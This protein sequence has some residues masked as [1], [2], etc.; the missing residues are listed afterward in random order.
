MTRRQFLKAVGLSTGLTL[1]LGLPPFVYTTR[2]EPTRVVVHPVRL[3]LPRLDPQFNGFKLVQI[4]DIHFD[5]VFMTGPR[6]Q[7][8]LTL[9]LKQRPDAVAIT[10]DFVTETVAPY[11]SALRDNLKRLAS[12]VPTVAVLGNH[13][14]WTDANAIRDILETS[15][16]RNVSNDLLTL[17]RDG[18]MLHLCG[19]DD[20]WERHHRLD[21]VLRKLPSTGAAV[22]LAHEPD[23]A[24]ESSLVGRFDL[25]LSGHSHGGQ[26]IVPFWGILVYPKMAYNYP[27]GQ[28]QVG[29]M[30]QYTNRGLGMVPP[31][32]RFNCRPEITVFTLNTSTD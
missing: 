12:A 22:L 25:Q 5:N 14:H 13:D 31:R 32:V 17:E 15:G 16:V 10:G 4:S 18:A 1:G 28:Y 19:V 23:Y 6:L 2:T 3:T 21:W 30:I 8:W 9:I 20:V 27:L 11:A 26:V 7:K 29:S 24:D